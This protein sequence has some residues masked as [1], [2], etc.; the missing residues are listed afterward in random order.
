MSRLSKSDNVKLVAFLLSPVIVMTLIY[1][2]GIFFPPQPDPDGLKAQRMDDVLNN[3][4]ASCIFCVGVVVLFFVYRMA[5]APEKPQQ[6]HPLDKKPKELH[7]VVEGVIGVVVV[8]V[9]AVVLT[10]IY[11]LYT[12]HGEAS[13]DIL[14]VLLS[15]YSFAMVMVYIGGTIKKKN[16]P[17]FDWMR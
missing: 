17:G 1:V 15:P 5:S 7:P 11:F 12:N 8:Y 3:V 6:R 13:G 16:G 2:A 4:L 10:Y 9:G 14:S